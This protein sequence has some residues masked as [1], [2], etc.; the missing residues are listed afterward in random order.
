M[1]L[2]YNIRVQLYCY[3]EIFSRGGFPHFRGDILDY[4]TKRAIKKTAKAGFG[5]AA[6]VISGALRVI[7][8]LFLILITTIAIFACIF[9]IYIKTNLASEDLGV[10]L[11]EYQLNETSVIYYYD[12]NTD[13]WVESASIVSEEGFMYWV[14]YS[15]IPKDMEHAL[16]AVEDR[17]FYKHH[18]VDWART[19]KAFV[20]MFLGDS[21]F[22]GSTLTQQLRKN[23]TGNNEATVRRKLTE[24][25]AALDMEK[26]YDKWQ[27][28]EWYLNWVNFGH[29]ESKGI[30]DAARYYF[31]KDVENLSLAEI[32]SIIGIT[33]NPSM[34]N[35]YYHPEANKR[36]QE[37]ILYLMYDQGYIDRQTYEEAK[38]EEL[39]F[40]YASTGGNSNQIYSWFDE[41]VREDVA[42]FLAEQRGI[43]VKAAKGILATGGFKIYSTMDPDIQAAVDKVYGSTDF[44]NSLKASGSSQQFQSAIVVT[45]PYTGNIVAL[46]GAVG[47]K[48]GN[49]LLNMATTSRRPPGS[50]FK[51][52]SVYAPAMDLG[53]ITPDT[54]YDDD[55]TELSGKPGWMPNNDDNRTH[56]IVSIRLAIHQSFNRISAQVLD[57]LTPENSYDFLTQKLRMNLE[58]SDEDYAPLCLGQ[59]TYGITVREMAQAFGIFPNEGQFIETRTFTQIYDSDWNLLYENEPESEN[60]ITPVTAYWMTDMLQGAVQRRMEVQG[61]SK[62]GTGYEASLGSM[63]TAGKTGTS[64]KRMDRWFVGFTPYYVAAVWTG[65]PYPASI[66]VSG[67]PASKIF[68]EIMTDIHEDL[69]VKEFNKPSNTYQPPVQGVETVEYYVHGMAYNGL[70]GTQLIYNEAGGVGIVGKEITV[71]APEIEGY[72]LV[73]EP[74]ATMT[75]SVEPQDNVVVFNY[76]PST[77]VIPD[78]PVPPVDNPDDPDDPG[79]EDPGSTGNPGG[80]DTP[81]GEDPGGTE[82]PEETEPPDGNPDNPDTPAPENPPPETDQPII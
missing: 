78:D 43:T 3:A 15:K 70:G 36:R 53:L 54:L 30:G 21:T 24:I 59:L 26:K 41:T 6:A 67:N 11:E 71:T 9:V 52:I 25:F 14:P 1:S 10:S 63:P 62:S 61:K 58:A 23:V 66:S 8:V 31:D 35:P 77:P 33:N 40:V 34:Y 4:K 68:K 7:G 18:G 72:D 73:S 16:V 80:T 76:V 69:P 47:E 81:G 55:A 20:Y 12:K 38:A 44:I 37:T 46:A 39:H 51:P 57:D 27:I 2:C 79:G 42:E 5:T 48:T 28:I 74:E 29:G 56:G 49:L 82:N 13:R 19:A 45:D 22:G 75:L 17:R 60:V 64:G 32:C 65:Y 50:S